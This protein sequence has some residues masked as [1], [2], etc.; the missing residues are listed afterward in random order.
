MGSTSYDFSV[1]IWSV[2]CIFGELLLGR[3]I[4]QGKTEIEQLQLIF[5][6]CGLPTKENWPDFDKMPGIK[7]ILL[8]EKYVCRLK[9]RFKT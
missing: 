8:E 7:D 6:L 5:G 3:P 9:D 1:D 4:L 2:G